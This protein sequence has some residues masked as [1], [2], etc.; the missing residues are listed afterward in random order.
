MSDLFCGEGKR[1]IEGNKRG[2]ILANIPHIIQRGLSSALNLI[3]LQEQSS[4]LRRPLFL[5]TVNL[6]ILH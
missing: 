6:Y 4:E 2:N 1:V 5:S 3:L